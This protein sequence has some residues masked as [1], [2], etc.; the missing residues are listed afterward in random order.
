MSAELI[1]ILVTVGIAIFLLVLG[2]VVGSTIEKRHYASIRERERKYRD[3]LLIPVR[4]PPPSMRGLHSEFVSGNVVIAID[5]FKLFL[6][7]F[8][9]LIG[10]RVSAYETLI[11]RARREAILRMK[12][13]AKAKNAKYILNVKFSTANIL[14]GQNNNSGGC[15]E[16]IAYGTALY[17]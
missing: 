2:F 11:E 5:R 4:T 8:R 14:S 13:E 12:E 7:F 10:G 1:E 3:I 6:A 16:V 17:P 9:N 15:V